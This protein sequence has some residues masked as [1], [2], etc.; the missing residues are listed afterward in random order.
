MKT[1]HKFNTATLFLTLLTVV[2][3]AASCGN[4]DNNLSRPDKTSETPTNNSEQLSQQ[5]TPPTDNGEVAGDVI[6][7]PTKKI[8]INNIE[9]EVEL[10]DTDAARSQGLSDRANLDDGRGMLFDFTKEDFK[11]PGFWMKDMLIS[12]DIIWIKDGKV[13]ALTPNA[14]LPPEE[15]ELPVYYPPVEISHVLEV[16]AG[17]SAKNNI[18]AGSDVKL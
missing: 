2:F 3:L 15:G 6:V 5:P 8:Q 18:T 13:V 9:V 14:P 1:K 10:A 11:K 12:I 17:W 7:N 16:P 4:N